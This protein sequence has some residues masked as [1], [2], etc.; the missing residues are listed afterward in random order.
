[1]LLSLIRRL[2]LHDSE[3]RTISKRP[4]KIYPSSQT[5]SGKLLYNAALSFVDCFA[6][7]PANGDGSERGRCAAPSR[8]CRPREQVYI[9]TVS[10]QNTN[11]LPSTL[12]QI[13][14]THRWL[15]FI[16][17]MICGGDDRFCCARRA[18]SRWQSCL[19]WRR[20]LQSRLHQSVC[21]RGCA[22]VCVCVSVRVKDHCVI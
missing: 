15:Q 3:L 5:A 1:L 2:I 19:R 14:C 13:R 17:L 4:V 10:I 9:C 8:L 12:Y 21:V 16:L 18:I 11:H 7:R 22:C 20:P 6:G